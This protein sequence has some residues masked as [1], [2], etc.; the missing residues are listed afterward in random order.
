[1]FTGHDD[2][3]AGRRIPERATAFELLLVCVVLVAGMGGGLEL[4]CG[5]LDADVEVL[6]DAVLELVEQFVGVAV[7]ETGV[8]QDD[9][10]GEHR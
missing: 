8:L 10:R 1:M 5:V 7:V 6:A 4:E 3:P 2:Q 9:M